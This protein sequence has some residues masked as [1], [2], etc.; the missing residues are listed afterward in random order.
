L[1]SS[2]LCFN[3]GVELG[4]LL[5]VALLVPALELLFRSVVP[6]RA[7]TVILSALIAHTAWHWMGERY[8]KLKQFPFERPALDAMLAASAVRWLVI[9]L[10]GLGLLWLLVRALREPREPEGALIQPED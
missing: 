4:Q 6:E 7:G 9:L 8:D 10:A 5:V 3:L 2:L 1:L